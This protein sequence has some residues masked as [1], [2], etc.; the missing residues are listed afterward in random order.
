MPLVKCD[1][2]HSEERF[3]SAVFSEHSFYDYNNYE[4]SGNAQ[5]MSEKEKEHFHM[6]WSLRSTIGRAYYLSGMLG[7][8]VDRIAGLFPRNVRVENVKNWYF[9]LAHVVLFFIKDK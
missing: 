4:S 7:T 6:D 5:C 2:T 8:L 1:R 9:I 3:V